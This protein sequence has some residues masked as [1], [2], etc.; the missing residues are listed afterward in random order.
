[1]WV[2]GARGWG[3]EG[4]SGSAS[5]QE[6]RPASP[7]PPSAPR[8]TCC[9]SCSALMFAIRNLGAVTLVGASHR[10]R[11]SARHPDSLRGAAA[12]GGAQHG[13]SAR[14]R[15]RAA[16]AA[17]PRHTQEE[18]GVRGPRASSINA[19]GRRGGTSETAPQGGG[20]GKELRNSGLSRSYQLPGH[21]LLQE[22]LLVPRYSWDPPPHPAQAPV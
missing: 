17:E 1:M 12:A 6:V 5:G 16:L 7:T 18:H 3:W 20:D 13:L 2:R 8:P 22:A 14:G 15:G 10:A 19:P 21:H 11:C 9:G 4:P